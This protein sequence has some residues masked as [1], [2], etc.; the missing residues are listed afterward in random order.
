V[1]TDSSALIVDVDEREKHFKATVKSLLTE[2]RFFVSFPSRQLFSADER[3]AT[4][5]ESVGASEAVAWLRS[6]AART[7]CTH[8]LCCE[9]F[10]YYFPHFVVRFQ[11]ATPNQ[12]IISW[13]TPKLEP[14]VKSEQGQKLI[15]AILHTTTSEPS[16]ATGA[17]ATSSASTSDTA[18]PPASTA[19]S[20]PAP[21]PAK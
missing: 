5:S 12:K 21:P 20:D 11:I 2:A 16:P 7:T 15:K 10:A 18:T 4:V 13:A 17:A 8:P 1:D 3:C 6:A 19:H 14:L 9:Y